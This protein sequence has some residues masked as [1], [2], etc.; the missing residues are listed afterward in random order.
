MLRTPLKWSIPT[1]THFWHFKE[2]R[3][4]ERV[5][6]E[7]RELQ[8][9]REFATAVASSRETFTDLNGRAHI[10][11]SSSRCRELCHSL[12]QIALPTADDG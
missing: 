10:N 9:V 11:Q 1:K 4:K 5:R 6:S 12:T 7:K 8:P 3:E 2:A